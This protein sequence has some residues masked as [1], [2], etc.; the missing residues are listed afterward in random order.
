MFLLGGF[1]FFYYWFNL[2]T[3][4]GSVEN[5]YFFCLNLRVSRKLSIASRLSNLLEN[6][7]HSTLLQS[8]QFCRV[9]SPLYCLILVT[10]I[11]SL[12]LNLAKGLSI[13]WSFQRPKSGF[14][15]FLHC[16]SILYFIYLWNFSILYF[17][18]LVFITFFLSAGLR[19]SLLFFLFLKG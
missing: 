9:L 19:F 18:Y 17:I 13:W 2:Y 4:H 5:F 8:F 15:D 6:T 16:F 10:C 1:F 12:L 14:T 7:V 3:C 11:F